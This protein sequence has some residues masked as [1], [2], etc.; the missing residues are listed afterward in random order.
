MSPES[1]LGALR[2]IQQ[3]Q[4][5]SHELNRL[6]P[7]FNN[8]TL[9]FYNQSTIAKAEAQLIK[10]TVNLVTMQRKNHRTLK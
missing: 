1:T 9:E 6:Q 8:T 5:V 4:W 7:C 3:Q 2:I 10:I